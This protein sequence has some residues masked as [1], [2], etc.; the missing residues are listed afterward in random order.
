MEF[1]NLLFRL[2]QVRVVLVHKPDTTGTGGEV[3]VPCE[4][5]QKL[6]AQSTAGIQRKD[7]ARAQVKGV[8][9][10]LVILNNHVRVLRS[11]TFV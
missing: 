10:L 7:V 3:G 9:G 5:S 2:L 8:V 1:G 11:S 6:R 4:F